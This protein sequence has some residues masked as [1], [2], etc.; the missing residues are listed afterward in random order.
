MSENEL[1]LWCEEL[2]SKFRQKYS[3]L[4]DEE[5]NNVLF[6]DNLNSPLQLHVFWFQNETSNIDLQLFFFTH[7]ENFEDLYINIYPPIDFSE[8]AK[9]VSE[10]LKED[11]YNE[12]IDPYDKNF[13]ANLKYSEYIENE[14]CNAFINFKNSLQIWLYRKN[15]SP[16]FISSSMS[17]TSPGFTWTIYGS[18]LNMTVERMLD[19][20]FKKLKSVNIEKDFNQT[21]EIKNIKQGY[22]CHVYPPIWLGMKPRLT[23]KDKLIGTR[24]Q[25]FIVDS[26]YTSYK[27]RAII[28][29]KDGF[30]AIEEQN[31]KM[32][33]KLLNEIMAIAQLYGFDFHLI[34]DMDLGDLSMDLGNH[35]IPSLQISGKTKRTEIYDERWKDLSEIYIWARNQI[36]SVDF[37]KIIQEAEKLIKNDEISNNLNL[38][39]GAYTHYYNNE[40]SMSYIMC[41]TLIEKKLVS[42]YKEVISQV[43]KDP[44]QKKRLVNKK[45]RIIDDKIE[46]LRIMGAISNEE[47]FQYMKFKKIRNR[48]IHKGKGAIEKETKE[49]LDF[50]RRLTKDFLNINR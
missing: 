20:I 16:L 4:T 2:I 39:L 23:L 37:K 12:D 45:F 44:I 11:I 46:L 29:E 26:I 15:R 50:S 32:A 33:L 28:I 19:N 42:S 14:I 27:K 31:R 47:Y 25:K 48:I 30:I 10:I 7:S 13:E 36:S 8:S 49:L 38:L 43:I 9:K 40:F 21:K 35:T 6:V 1:R 17:Y 41:W 3:S 18:V 24:F 5:K 22:G 34:R